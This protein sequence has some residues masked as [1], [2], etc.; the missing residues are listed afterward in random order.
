MSCLK[1]RRISVGLGCVLAVFVT[2]L[3]SPARA[4]AMDGRTAVGECIDS[5]AS[6][7][8]CAWSVNDKGE[9]D[10]CNKSGCIY[11]AS[12]TSEC[13]A[14]AKGRPRPTSW[15]PPGTKV[16]TSVGEFEVKPRAIRGSLLKAPTE[17]KLP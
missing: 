11:C 15:L 9:I 4:H 6:G 7:A 1:S 5:T 3:S 17:A 8:R 14:A 10:V 13:T 16:L 2:I 12:A